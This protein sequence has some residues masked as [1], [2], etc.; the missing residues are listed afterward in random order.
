MKKDSYCLR[1]NGTNLYFKSLEG[2]KEWFIKCGVKKRLVLEDEEYLELDNLLD[3]VCEGEIEIYNDCMCEMGDEY[4]N[5]ELD[6][7]D[8]E[9]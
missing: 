6:V 3:I 5:I 1:I 7:I 2:V 9:D 4:C 8:F